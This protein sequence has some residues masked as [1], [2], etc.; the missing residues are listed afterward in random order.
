[1]PFYY[2]ILRDAFRQ[3]H[4]SEQGIACLLRHPLFCLRNIGFLK[5]AFNIPSLEG[6]HR[7]LSVFLEMAYHVGRIPSHTSHQS[8]GQAELEQHPD[9]IETFM[10]FGNSPLRLWPA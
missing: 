7:G 3:L 8:G 5:A 4:P 1:M 2:F 6:W 10:S 9:K